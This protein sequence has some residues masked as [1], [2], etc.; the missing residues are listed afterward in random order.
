MAVEDEIV[1]VEGGAERLD[2]LIAERVP[3]RHAWFFVTPEGDILP[4]GTYTESGHVIDEQG[5]VFAFWTGWDPA[6]NAVTFEIWEQDEPE[7]SW[8]DSVEYRQAREA[9]GLGQSGAA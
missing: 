7:Q 6:R 1:G 2:Q 3:G 5:R 9:V 4:D 8:N